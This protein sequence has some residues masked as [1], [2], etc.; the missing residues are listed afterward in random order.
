M[1][2]TVCIDTPTAWATVRSVG[3][4][5]SRRPRARRSFGAA[6]D[7]P[8]DCPDGSP[9][10]SPRMDLN[11]NIRCATLQDVTQPFLHDLVT[12]VRAPV[13]VLSSPDGQIRAD[14]AQGLHWL[15]RRRLSS[16]LVT[17]D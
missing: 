14:G 16:L 1:F 8:V 12:C 3:W 4:A 9:D 11:V 15:D 17:V 13:T 2:D 6:G 5:P 7:V 10:L